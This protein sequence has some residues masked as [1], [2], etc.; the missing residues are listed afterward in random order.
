MKAGEGSSE[1]GEDKGVD[2]LAMGLCCGVAGGGLLLKE[3]RG[4]NGAGGLGAGAGSVAVGL[5]G[6]SDSQ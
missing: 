4:T 6:R 3:A 5:V 1:E 2:S